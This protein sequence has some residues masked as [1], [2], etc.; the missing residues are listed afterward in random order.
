MDRTHEAN[1]WRRGFAAGIA[2]LA[3]SIGGQIATAPGAH[4]A[5]CPLTAPQPSI[6]QQLYDRYAPRMHPHTV[7]HRVA[8]ALLGAM[9]HE[10]CS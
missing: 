5:S 2:A 1:T 8:L 7:A 4:E 9:L 3:L 10:S 6:A